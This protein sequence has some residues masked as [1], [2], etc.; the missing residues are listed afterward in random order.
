[1]HGLQREYGEHITFVRVNIHLEETRELQEQYGFTLAPEFFLV[2]M[3]GNILDYWDDQI[4][5]TE[6]KATFDRLLHL[7]P[8]G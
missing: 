5:V 2:D 1:V 4:T 3:D 8:P 6:L 7:P